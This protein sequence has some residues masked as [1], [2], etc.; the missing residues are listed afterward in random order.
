MCK[1]YTCST[2]TLQTQ[3]LTQA[4]VGCILVAKQTTNFHKSFASNHPAYLYDDTK[5][6]IVNGNLSN[7]S[8][9]FVKSS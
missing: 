5:L 9:S 3:V 2:Y 6:A 1:Y 7:A 8:M 4:P